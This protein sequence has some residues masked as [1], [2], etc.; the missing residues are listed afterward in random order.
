MKGNGFMIKEADKELLMWQRGV[1]IL[2]NGK[3]VKKMAE[4]YFIST[5]E[6]FMMVCDSIYNYQVIGLPVDDMVE[7]HINGLME[8]CIVESGASIR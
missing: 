7:E 6:M 2:V 8:R 5:Q 4:V 1:D 3:R